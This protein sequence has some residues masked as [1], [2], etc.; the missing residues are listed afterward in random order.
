VDQAEIPVPPVD[1]LVAPAFS[2][3][4]ASTPPDDVVLNV[5]VQSRPGAEKSFSSDG[6]DSRGDS[7]TEGDEAPAEVNENKI[8]AVAT[9]R[10]GERCAGAGDEDRLVGGGDARAQVRGEREARAAGA[11]GSEPM[12][13][14]LYARYVATHTK[15]LHTT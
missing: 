6:G 1:P 14:M 12:M 10:R 8:V 9:R 3:A 15:V 4:L 7:A 11:A 5:A 13:R 2:K